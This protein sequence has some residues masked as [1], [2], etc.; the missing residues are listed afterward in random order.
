[1][2]LGVVA[3]LIVVGLFRRGGL[4][5][6]A[7]PFLMVFGLNLVGGIV[8][9]AAR[10]SSEADRRNREMDLVLVAGKRHTSE[11]ASSDTPRSSVIPGSPAMAMTASLS[12]RSPDIVAETFWQTIPCDG[13]VVFVIGQGESL[14]FERSVY[15]GFHGKELTRQSVEP[16]AVRFA[17]ETLKRGRPVVMSRR[18]PEWHYA[19]AAPA[20]RTLLGVPVIVGKEP[21][22]VVILFN[23]RATAASPEREFTEDQFRLIAAL[24]YQSAALLENARRYQLEYA[25]FDGFARSLAKAVDFRDAYTRG[26]S[27]RVADLSKGIAA[28]LGLTTDEIE[29]VLRA[30]TLHD[31]GKIGINDTLLKKPGKLSREEFAA[32]RAHAANGFEILKAAPSFEALLPGIRHHHERYDGQGYPDGLAGNSIPLLAR[33][34]AVADAYDAMTS[35]RPYRTAL[36]DDRACAELLEGAGT[37]FD[38]QIV[39][40]ILRHLRKRGGGRPSAVGASDVSMPESAAPAVAAGA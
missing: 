6:D 34:I 36:L 5:V 23:K 30:A 3:V 17:W 10:A 20:L 11:L 22:A 29:V 24:R 12:V 9:N 35:D 7:S 28:E 2:L 19:N 27:E 18:S 32:I 1:M 16:M 38:P 8:V 39:E 40:A 14:T 37:Q 33:I 25:M 13:C 31:L 21:L 26:H 15:Q 4:V